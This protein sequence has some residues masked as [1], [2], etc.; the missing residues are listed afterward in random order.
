MSHGCVRLG[1][2]FEL[3]EAF[4]EIEPKI[5]SERSKQILEENKKTPYRL[6]E[7]IPVDIVYLTTLVAKDGTV[8]FFDDVYGYDKLQLEQS[9]R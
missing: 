3:L 4:A 7:S 6:S 2:P 8:M 5:D 1:K 9:K